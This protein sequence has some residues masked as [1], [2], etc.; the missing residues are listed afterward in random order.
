MKKINADLLTLVFIAA[1]SFMLA[2]AIHEHGG[3]S[4]ACVLQGGHISE[5]GAFYVDC[6]STS[7]SD[8]GNRMVAV[9]GPLVS[10]LTGLIASAYFYRNQRTDAALTFFLWH[11]ATVNLMIGAGYFLFSGVAGIGDLGTDESGA[12][13]GVK[14]E[15]LVREGLSILGLFLYYVVIRI[16]IKMMD[17]NC[18]PCR[19]WYCYFDRSS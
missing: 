8:L 3:H 5:M 11:F 14:P 1:F 10:L 12:F 13:Q 2:T 4:L 9:A 15:W 17:C 16:S 18:I 19:R 6:K 7:L